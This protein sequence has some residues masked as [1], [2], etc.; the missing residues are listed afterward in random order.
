MKETKDRKGLAKSE[1]HFDLF[2]LEQAMSGLA[3]GDNNQK[4]QE[5][6]DIQPPMVDGASAVTAESPSAGD[7]GEA[8]VKSLYELLDEQHAKSLQ[9]QQQALKGLAANG[10]LTH[11]HSIQPLIVSEMG[12]G[13]KRRDFSFK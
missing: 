2:L 7:F 3:F 13:L 1:T 11:N 12:G 8:P 4:E 9:E 5:A 6:S 10:F